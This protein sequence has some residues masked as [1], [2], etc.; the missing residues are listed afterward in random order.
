MT[1]LITGGTGFIGSQLARALLAA[2]QRVRLMGRDFSR[3]GDVLAAGAEAVQA[4]LR[5]PGQVFAAC[6]GAAVVYHVGALSTPWGAVA[7]LPRNQRGGDTSRDRRLHSASGGPPDPRL[8]AQC[9]L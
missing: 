8:L 2:G 4:D 9:G 6:A 1:I 3:V 5:D 7:R